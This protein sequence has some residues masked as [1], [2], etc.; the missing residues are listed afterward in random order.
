MR[1]CT[2]KIIGAWVVYTQNNYKITKIEHQ[3]HYDLNS[4]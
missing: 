4:I 2:N 3:G 1:D